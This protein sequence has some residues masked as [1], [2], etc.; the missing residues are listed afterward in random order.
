MIIAKKKHTRDLF[1]FMLIL[2]KGEKI[3]Q[4]V[5][6]MANMSKSRKVC[7]IGTSRYRSSIRP[8]YTK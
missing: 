2:K 3:E 5:Y 4:P 6:S 1:K 7:R 8:L